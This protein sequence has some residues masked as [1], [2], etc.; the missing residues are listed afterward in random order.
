[1]VKIN[2]GGLIELTKV[3][4]IQSAAMGKMPLNSEKVSKAS[5]S[6]VKVGLP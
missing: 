2:Y 4:L 1:M 5:F 3:H 6:E